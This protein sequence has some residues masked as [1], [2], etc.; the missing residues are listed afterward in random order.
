MI[1]LAPVLAV[2]TPAAP[3]TRDRVGRCSVRRETGR[4][5]GSIE[6]VDGLLLVDRRIEGGGEK[7][8]KTAVTVLKME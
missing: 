1:T 5:R 6:G 4:P 3:E 8:K 2:I 7:K